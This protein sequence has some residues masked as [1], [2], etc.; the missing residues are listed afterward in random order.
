MLTNDF[1]LDH[2]WEIKSQTSL[3]V[4]RNITNWIL[5][6]SC[7]NSIIFICYGETFKVQTVVRLQFVFLSEKHFLAR[8]ERAVDTK[9][10]QAETA[11]RIGTPQS[12]F[13]RLTTICERDR[14]IGPQ[15]KLRR[16]ASSLTNSYFRCNYRTLLVRT[17]STI[18]PIF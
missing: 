5:I 1:F 18:D 15:D 13:R 16:T 2:N 6:R 12:L 7:W 17:M 11:R 8:K 4:T 14:R 3:F 10:G 9:L